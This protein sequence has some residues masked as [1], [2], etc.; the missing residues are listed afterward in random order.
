MALGA[1]D[2]RHDMRLVVLAHVDAVLRDIGLILLLGLHGDLLGVALV[3]PA[4]VHDLARDRR[5]EHTE[6]AAGSQ[7]V[8]NARHIVDKAHVEHAVGLV[9]HDGLDVVELD[10]TA[11]HVVAQAARRR[12][13][14]LRVLFE[15]VDLLADGRAAV[16][17]HDAHARKIDA[18]VAQLR[19]DLHGELARG[20]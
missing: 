3:H 10:G 12:D 16:Q 18:K 17:A 2:L 7:L 15:R 9:E 19:R 13:D 4:D 8:Q 6:I 1:D 14:D 5:G 11:L 20:R